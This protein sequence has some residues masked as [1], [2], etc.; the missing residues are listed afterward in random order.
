VDITVETIGIKLKSEILVVPA[1]ANLIGL[2]V[3]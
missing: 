1:M 2:P 3:V